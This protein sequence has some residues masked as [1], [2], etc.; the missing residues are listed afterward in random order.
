MGQVGNGAG[1]KER[2]YDSMKHGFTLGLGGYGNRWG[3]K[4]VGKKGLL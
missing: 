2:G 1:I 3:R 4:G